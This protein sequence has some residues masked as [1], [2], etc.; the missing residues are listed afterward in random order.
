MGDLIPRSFQYPENEDWSLQEDEKEEFLDTVS[1]LRRIWPLLTA[2]QLFS[3]AMKDIFRGYVWE[4]KGEATGLVSYQRRG[5]ANSWVI[6]NVTVAPESRR[7]GIGLALVSAG[8][9]DLRERGAETILLDVISGNIPAYSLYEKLG[10]KHYTGKVEFNFPKDKTMPQGA[11]PE[12]YELVPNR[13]SEWR[14]RFELEQRI[15][16]EEVQAVEPVEEKRFRPPPLVRLLVPIIDR[17]RGVKDERYVLRDR[18][19][20]QVVGRALCQARTR[21]GGINLLRLAVHAAHGEL[22]LALVKAVSPGRRIELT[23]PLW[24]EAVVEA[25][26]Q[27]GYEERVI[28]HRMGLRP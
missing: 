17:A 10:F 7:R 8:V 27:A 2:V 24:Q 11:L 22:A 1:S 14:P 9:E 3:P 21:P 28:Y 26:R 19:E 20:H 23:V 12:R 16:P 18:A 25:A 13:L 15:M 6:I 5:R 4:E